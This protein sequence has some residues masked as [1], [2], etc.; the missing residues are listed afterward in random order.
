VWINLPTFD[1]TTGGDV[2]DRLQRDARFNIA[3][4]FL[5]PFLIPAAVKLAA[6]AF[7]PVTLESPQT[8]IWTMTAWA[9]L[10]ASLF[11]RGIAMG[12][13]AGMIAEKRRQN[14][15]SAEESDFLLA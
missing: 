10:P 6:L 13:I 3:L 8:L 2:V 14:N 5:L 15:S 12:R 11:M 4:G 1:P 7:V 9:F